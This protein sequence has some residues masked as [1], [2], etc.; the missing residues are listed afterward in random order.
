MVINI[1]ALK[2]GDHHF[3]EQQISAIARTAHHHQALCKVIIE[4]SYLTDEEKALLC[5][6]AVRAGADFVKTSTGFSG[7]GA[8]V[9]DIALMRR[10]VGPNV[11]VKASGGVRSLADA[12]AMIKAG[13][14]R[15]GVSSGVGIVKEALA[16]VSHSEK[17]SGTRK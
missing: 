8:T 14:N 7:G 3:V 2:G 17:T 10:T 1:G 9:E 15:I 4:T 6:M 13:A 11:G 16:G 12:I 5:E